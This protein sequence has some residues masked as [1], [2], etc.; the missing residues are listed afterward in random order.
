MVTAWVGVLK[1]LTGSKLQ[2][3]LGYQPL[4]NPTQVVEPSEVVHPEGQG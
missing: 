4:K 1:D 2:G 3:M